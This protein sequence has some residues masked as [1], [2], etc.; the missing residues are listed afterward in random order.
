MTRRFAGR[1]AL[2]TG[3]ASGIGRATGRL[4]ALEGATV[5]LADLD[6]AAATRVAEEIVSAGGSAAGLGLDVA[7]EAAWEAASELLRARFGRLDV[8]VNCA[9]IAAAS[10][11]ADT[12]LDA[13][14]RVLAVN[15]DGV[16]LGTR[17][18]VRL[19]RPSG[20]GSVVNVS[21]ASGIKAAAASSAYCASKAAVLMLTKVVALECAKD[22][23]GIRVNAVAPGAVKTPMW[24]TTEGV[25]A[26]LDSAEWKAPPEAPIGSRF[27]DPDE[28]ARAI[29]FL[30]SPEA[31]YVTGAVLAVDAGYTA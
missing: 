27:A 22:G 21:S 25:S 26:V 1:V 7:S 14:R 4:L 29:L 30:A 8:L 15:L 20:G 3:G 11:V 18:A 28:V 17:M 31:S 16:F 6:E 19:M 10:P 23:S 12:S 5:V 9:G 2:V 13:W 24:A